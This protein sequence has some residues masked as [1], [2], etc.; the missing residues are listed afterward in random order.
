M[1]E[2]VFMFTDQNLRELLEYNAPEGML[3]FYLTTDPAAGGAEAHRLQMRTLLKKI[4]LPQDV[5]AV[6]QYVER[7]YDWSSKGLAIFSCAAKKFFRAYPL[8]LPVRNLAQVTRRAQVKALVNLF[9]NYSGYGVALVDKQ[10]ARLFF[11]HLGELREQEGVLGEAVKHV[12]HGGA[13]AVSGRRG[14]VAGQ[15]HYEDEVVGR[16]MKDAAEFAARFFEEN[17]VRRVLL[18]GSED[19]I[20]AFRSYLPKSWQS[21]VVGVFPMSMTASHTEVLNK[22]LQTG[23][24]AEQAHETRRI[25]EMVNLAR[26]GGNAIVGLDVTLSAVNE[27][28]VQTLVVDENLQVL[29]YHCPSC[30]AVSARQMRE[31]N[32]CNGKMDVVSDVIEMAVAATLRADGEVDIVSGQ[33][34][35]AEYGSVGAMLRY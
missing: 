31:C 6:E 8:G 28:R 24:Q 12:K 18:G 32:Y 3:S 20:A 7:E 34:A 19:N 13:S 2:E 4:Y 26:K 10:G 17:H 15:T 16:N 33:P 1:R 25:Q 27:K 5:A 29:G 23:K 14:G 30:G 11:F 22:A 35:F 9:D 21:L